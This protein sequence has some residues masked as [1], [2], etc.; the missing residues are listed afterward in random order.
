MVDWTNG[1]IAA[2]SPS[3]TSPISF[4]DELREH[5][6]SWYP[7]TSTGIGI[8]EGP[9]KDAVGCQYLTLWTKNQDNIRHHPDHLL[10]SRPSRISFT[11]HHLREGFLPEIKDCLQPPGDIPR[12][13]RSQWSEGE[14]IADQI[15]HFDPAGNLP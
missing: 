4:S 9:E 8:S 14:D 7:E 2:F 15:T 1:N 5:K 12:R 6:S 3:M 11:P 13:Q 10:E